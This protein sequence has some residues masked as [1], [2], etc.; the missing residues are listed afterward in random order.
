MKCT[1]A[2]WTKV[3]CKIPRTKLDS[4][5][6]REDYAKIIMGTLGLKIFEPLTASAT[7]IAPNHDSSEGDDV[8]YC[9]KRSGADSKISDLTREN[10]LLRDEN[11]RLKGIIN[12]DSSNTSLH[13]KAISQSM[14]S[15][16]MLPM[17][18][19]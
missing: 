16:L 17:V 19:M 3:A 15:I 4:C 2:N 5:K 13:Q 12:N 14:L 11:T 18:L 6:G 7:T 9:I 10:Q 1:L 8:I